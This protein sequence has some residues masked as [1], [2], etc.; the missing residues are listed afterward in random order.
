MKTIFT[1]NI[2]AILE[3]NLILAQTFV[4]FLFF[5]CYTINFSKASIL[6]LHLNIEEFT[7]KPLFG[8][9]YFVVI[10]KIVWLL[11]LFIKVTLYYFFGNLIIYNPDL[12][13]NG[14]ISFTALLVMVL[15]VFYCMKIQENPSLS[16]FYDKH[17]PLLNNLFLFPFIL[18][19]VI[20]LIIT[21][22]LNV[23]FANS[24][25]K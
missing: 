2:Y 15:C 23:D 19:S 11:I 14:N 13:I 9:I 20:S 3:N 7:L 4:V 22:F 1:K 24:E 21:I 6:I 25:K 12:K 5:E 16:P 18:A 8:F 10:C 17:N